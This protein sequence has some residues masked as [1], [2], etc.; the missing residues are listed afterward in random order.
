MTEAIP[1]RWCGH[2]FLPTS[3]REVH[4]ATCRPRIIERNRSG[5]HDLPT[6]RKSADIDQQPELFNERT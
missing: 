4:C 2:L 5:H 1:C 3:D 6:A